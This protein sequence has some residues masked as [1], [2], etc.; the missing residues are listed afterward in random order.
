MRSKQTKAR[1]ADVGPARGLVRFGAHVA[2]VVAHPKTPP[3]L[4][5]A[6]QAII[7]NVV[8]NESGYEWADDEEGLRFLVPRYLYQ[9]NEAYA[10]GLIHALSELIADSLPAGLKQEI[11]SKYG[12]PDA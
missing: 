10:T 1:T 7:V 4:K 6:L 9:M 2:R 11:G 12:D 5:S 3:A 8:S